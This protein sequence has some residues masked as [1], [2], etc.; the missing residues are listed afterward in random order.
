MFILRDFSWRLVYHKQLQHS[1][2]KFKID[3]TTTLLLI[4]R[5]R[6]RRLS[7]DQV[8]NGHFSALVTTETPGLLPHLQEIMQYQSGMLSDVSLKV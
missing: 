1:L 6:R 7:R 8:T 3:L 2:D 4:T 5:T